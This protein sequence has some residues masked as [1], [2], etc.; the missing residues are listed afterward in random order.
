MSA[1]RVK[2]LES[3]SMRG[4]R[5]DHFWTY[6]GVSKGLEDGHWKGEIAYCPLCKKYALWS[7][8]DKNGRGFTFIGKK[9]YQKLLIPGSENW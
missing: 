7:S 1:L 9:N 4:K 3:G 5:N 2:N 8:Q 6:A